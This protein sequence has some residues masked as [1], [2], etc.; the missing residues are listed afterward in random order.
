[1]AC[2]SRIDKYD[3]QDILLFVSVCRSLGGKFVVIG[4]LED[5]QEKQ[6]KL[7]AQHERP[8]RKIVNN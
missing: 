8:N 7:H 3:G 4:G 2:A 5:L 6:R 1:M